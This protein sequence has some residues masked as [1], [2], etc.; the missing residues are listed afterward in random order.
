M[1]EVIGS[2]ILVLAIVFSIIGWLFLWLIADFDA[3]I[4]KIERENRADKLFR[5]IL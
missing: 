4:S 2:D 3:R 1:K 5:D